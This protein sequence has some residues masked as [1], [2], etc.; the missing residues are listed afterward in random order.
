MIDRSS[1]LRI[2]AQLEELE[3]TRKQREPGARPPQQNSGETSSPDGASPE[4]SKNAGETSAQL[5][6][7]GAKKPRSKGK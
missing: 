1:C 6:L 7:A 3:K 4:P 2:R 5:E